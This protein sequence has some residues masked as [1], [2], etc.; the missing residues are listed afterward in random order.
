MNHS[1]R[2]SSPGPTVSVLLL[3]YNLEQYIAQA[4]DSVLMQ[5]VE[6]P[7][8]IVVAED[9]S[10]DNTR[11]IIQQYAQRHPNI[12][13]PIFRPHNLGM[14]VN[15]ARTLPACRGQYVAL[16]DADDYWTSPHK[17]R[18]QVEL[19][20]ANPHFSF[21]FHNVAVLYEDGDH[22]THPFHMSQPAYYL[23][24]TIPAAVLSLEDLLPGNFIQTCSVVF[25]NG[26]F[27]ALPDWFCDMPTYD[28]PL[29]IFNAQRGPFAYIDEVWGVYRVHQRGLWSTQMSRYENVRDTL[30]MIDAYKRIDHHLQ[31]SYTQQLHEP[32]I[33]LYARA[34]RL[35]AAQG[36][37]RYSAT[38]LYRWLT[39]IL[40]PQNR[41]PRR[42]WLH[43]TTNTVRQKAAGIVRRTIPQ[44][45]G[46][47]SDRLTG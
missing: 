39:H 21:C 5:E 4:L 35:F 37:Y 16:L 41:R 22:P 14:N 1:S 40:K 38:Y 42:E 10:T 31:H 30:N 32:I 46:K 13:R 11:M 29:H 36:S 15:F 23:S 47:S 25:R 3:A 2:I 26:L 43:R 24:R 33:P 28:W 6:F 12:V 19:L 8:E 7:Y 34:A 17:L 18:S 9:N 45:Q 20:Q 27:D 44:Q